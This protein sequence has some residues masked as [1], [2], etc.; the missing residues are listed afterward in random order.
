MLLDVS[1]GNRHLWPNKNPP[2]TVFLDK[3]R[4]LLIPPDVIASWRALP[5]RDNCFSCILFDPPNDPSWGS[6]SGHR[7]PK[8]RKAR[9]WGN[10]ASRRNLVSDIY[11]GQK[12]FA[13]ISPRLCLKWNET[14]I[15]LEA[16]LSLFDRWD[17]KY[18][19]EYLS[20]KKRGGSSTFWVTLIRK[21]LR[22]I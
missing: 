16:I 18:R 17:E 12:E 21:K 2:E 3:E 7:D 15:T 8:G 6:T 11:H 20:R 5:F 19:L 9:F 4:D 1:A 13:R 22:Y 14:A 10:P